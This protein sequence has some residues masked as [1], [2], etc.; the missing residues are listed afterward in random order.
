L[1]TLLSTTPAVCHIFRRLKMIEAAI[2]V[3]VPVVDALR[4]AFMGRA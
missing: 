3:K 1:K 4:A 2:A